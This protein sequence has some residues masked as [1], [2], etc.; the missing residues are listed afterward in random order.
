M[1]IR[2]TGR[3]GYA[4][5][6]M[7]SV[8]VFIRHGATEEWLAGDLG[9]NGVCRPLLYIIFVPFE[10]CCVACELYLLVTDARVA[11]LLKLTSL[12]SFG[13]EFVFL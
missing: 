13:F 5:L 2:I 10:Q 6:C 11:V 8:V 3:P 12:V 9:S 4:A 1:D 7:F